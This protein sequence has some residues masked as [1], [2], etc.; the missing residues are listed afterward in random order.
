MSELVRWRQVQG[1]DWVYKGGRWV[2]YGKELSVYGEQIREK[3][4]LCLLRN[5]PP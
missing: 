1:F 4:F 2:K 5:T 3:V